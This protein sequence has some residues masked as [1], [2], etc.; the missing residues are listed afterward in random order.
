MNKKENLEIELKKL[1]IT[2]QAQLSQAISKGGALD[3]S[4]MALERAGTSNNHAIRKA[5]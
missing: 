4:L 1:G 5:G 2:N 3:I